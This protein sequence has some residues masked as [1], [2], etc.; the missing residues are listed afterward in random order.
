MEDAPEWAAR[1]CEPQ[2]H[3]LCA[4]CC[5]CRGN[6]GTE[7]WGAARFSLCS[8]QAALQPSS[9]SYSG[10]WGLPVS[11]LA[12]PCH[13]GF[14]T[15]PILP[16]AL[17]KVFLPCAVACSSG[18]PKAGGASVGHPR[19]G[20]EHTATPIRA[21]ASTSPPPRAEGMG[22]LQCHALPIPT[23]IPIFPLMWQPPACLLLGDIVHVPS[24]CPGSCGGGAVRSGACN[25]D[26]WGWLPCSVPKAPW[27][28]SCH[29]PRAELGD[30]TH[31]L[32]FGDIGWFWC[33]VGRELLPGC[34]CHVAG[35]ASLL[36]FPTLPHPVVLVPP[37][38]CW[39]QLLKRPH[40]RETGTSLLARGHMD[41][42]AAWRAVGL[43]MGLVVGY[44]YDG[45][46]VGSPVEFPMVSPKRSPVGSALGSPMGSPVGIP[47][48]STT[49]LTVGF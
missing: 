43:G 24:P 31:P 19:G 27:L 8:L 14:G 11:S 40:T 32:S 15:V 6:R 44:E 13:Q 10:H 34:F 2:T 12:S 26:S 25:G 45:S 35:R 5:W 28:H 30:G 17:P 20:A 4:V 36:P 42:G 38:L 48:G 33:G 18:M 23:E 21:I 46:A 16:K 49:R 39:E 7:G 1:S 22:P 37:L 9:Q 3:P 41:T 47:V 29:L